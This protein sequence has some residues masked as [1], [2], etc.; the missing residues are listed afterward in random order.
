MQCSHN[1]SRCNFS[2]DFDT[3]QPAMQFMFVYKAV[4]FV[5]EG[6]AHNVKPRALVMQSCWCIRQSWLCGSQEHY[7]SRV[8]L[9][10]VRLK[11]ALL[12]FTCLSVYRENVV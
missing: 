10:G 11:A 12:G 5:W 4:M 6:E 1:E 9:K 8:R 7:Y 3:L 2:Q